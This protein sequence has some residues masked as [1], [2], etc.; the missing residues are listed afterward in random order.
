MK[1]L[2]IGLFAIAVAIIIHA[3]NLYFWYERGLLGVCVFG[4]QMAFGFDGSFVLYQ[5]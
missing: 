5:G 1:S 2:N 3:S 4:L